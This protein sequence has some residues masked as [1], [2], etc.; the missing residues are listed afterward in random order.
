MIRETVVLGTTSTAGAWL[1]VVGLVLLLEQIPVMNEV[2][3]LKVQAVQSLEKVIEVP[4]LKK[5]QTGVKA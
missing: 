2:T 4:F 3:S 5:A 1:T